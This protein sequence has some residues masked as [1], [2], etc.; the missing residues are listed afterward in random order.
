MFFL[1]YH[2]PFLPVLKQGGGERGG[3]RGGQNY[4]QFNLFATKVFFFWFYLKQLNF[5]V[6]KGEAEKR[7]PF[8]N[9]FPLLLSGTVLYIFRGLF[10]FPTQTQKLII[11]LNHLFWVFQGSLG[12]GLGIKNFFLSVFFTQQ[13]SCIVFLLP[14][15]EGV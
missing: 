7:G 10:F 9:F 15:G 4:L 2:Y 8:R 12:G 5:F 14:F 1:L 3:G 13:K 6:S 11:F